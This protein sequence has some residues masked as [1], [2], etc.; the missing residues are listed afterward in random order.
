MVEFIMGVI[1]G[2]LSVGLFWYRQLGEQYHP[3]DPLA[4][5]FTPKRKN[6]YKPRRH[7]E[8]LEAIREQK[9]KDNAE[10]PME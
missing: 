1:V 6:K 5:Q 8:E 9:I 7:S 4:P 3:T 2:S 10:I